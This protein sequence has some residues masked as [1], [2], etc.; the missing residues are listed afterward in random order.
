MAL[1]KYV[2]AIQMNSKV[3]FSWSFEIQLRLNIQKSASPSKMS[4]QYSYKHHYPVLNR[5]Y[6]FLKYVFNFYYLWFAI[7]SNFYVP[8]SFISGYCAYVAHPALLW[9][10][11]WRGQ[12]MYDFVGR[13]LG[14]VHI[15][16]VKRPGQLSKTESEWLRRW[17]ANPLLCECVSSNSADVVTW[18]F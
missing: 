10:W 7:V 2:W 15:K 13:S 1:L 8:K 4:F 6:I 12:L 3:I 14:N 18:L 5:I 17:I 16:V 9:K 11:C